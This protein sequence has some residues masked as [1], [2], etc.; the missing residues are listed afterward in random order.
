MYRLQRIISLL[1]DFGLKDPY[2]GVMKGVIYSINPYAIV[3]DITH[4]VPKFNIDVASTILLVS[5]KYFPKG[6]IHVCVV[7]PGVGT[8]RKAILIKTRN[9]FFIGPDN[10][11]LYK[12]VVDDGIVE[13]YDISNS[14]YSLKN[15][16][17]TFHGRDL[18]SPVA[19]YLSIGIPPDKLGTPYEGELIKPSTVGI[20]ILNSCV[21]GYIVY[22]DGFGNLMTNIES[23]YVKEIGIDY[24]KFIKVFVGGNEFKCLYEKSF[25]YVEKGG[26]ISYI[27]SWGYLEI[28]VNQGSAAEKLRA[29]VGEE[30][31]V[32]LD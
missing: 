30:V 3:V 23:R 7:D 24:G 2:V 4:D 26:F 19:A 12:A 15:K 22:I 6:T 32:C 17:H 10:G 13:V 20:E 27:N 28:G 8:S 31:K 16:S 25:G 21:K 9:Y 18:F 1:T 11:C 5:Y 29:Y 14:P